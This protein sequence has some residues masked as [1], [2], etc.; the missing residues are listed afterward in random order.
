MKKLKKQPKITYSAIY[1]DGGTNKYQYF[2]TV[3]PNKTHFS[4]LA[5]LEKALINEDSEELDGLFIVKTEIT[6]VIEEETQKFKLV[7]YEK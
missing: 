5:A 6:H 4:S 1:D 7:P 3:D 2:Y